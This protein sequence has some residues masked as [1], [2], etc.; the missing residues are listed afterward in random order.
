MN[1]KQKLFTAILGYEPKECFSSAKDEGFYKVLDKYNNETHSES[2]DL[3][4]YLDQY[5]SNALELSLSDAELYEVAEALVKETG[6]DNS[7]DRYHLF[8]SLD[9]WTAA[10]Y[11]KRGN[12]EEL[13]LWKMR[14]I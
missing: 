3:T 8:D 11:S 4:D 2:K 14:T 13:R 10:K 1:N 6:I 12:L 5:A 7:N 9:K